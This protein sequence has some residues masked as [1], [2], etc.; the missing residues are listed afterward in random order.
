MTRLETTAETPLGPFRIAAEGEAIVRLTWGKGR[1]QES[2]L[3]Q[4]AARQLLSYARGELREFDLPLAPRGPDFQ[5]AVWREMLKIPYGETR[6]YGDLAVSLDGI[7]RAVGTACGA[8][9]IPVIIPCHRVIAG[10]G[11][12]GG[13]S[14]AG[15]VETKRQLLVH[16]GAILE[17]LSFF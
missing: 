17:Q 9:P 3:L 7:A 2:P 12:L 8:N 16:E 1:D 6:S 15:G 11:E 13:F 14:G 5:K 10:N 4:E